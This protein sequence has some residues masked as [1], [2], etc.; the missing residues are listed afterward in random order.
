[1]ADIKTFPAPWTLHGYGYIILFKA[2]SE[3]LKQHGF[4]DAGNLD[5]YVP[6]VGTAMLVN[7]ESSTAGGYGELLFIPGKFQ[8]PKGK[9]YSISKIF[10]STME[11]VINGQ[12][13]WGIPKE[14]AQFEFTQEEQGIEHIR[15]K[16]DGKLI[17]DCRIQ[18]R[19][20]GMPVTT[21][22]LPK[23]LRTVAQY[24]K[25]KLFYTSPNA[26]S[27]LKLSKLLSAEFNTEHFPDLNQVKILGVVKADNMTME[28]PVPE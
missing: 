6:S 17:A 20:W 21:A 28:F 1:M 19:S 2:E 3:W 26:R 15:I 22:L 7:Y 13:N 23:S 16:K 18:T 5:S 4:I 24:W 8:M 9:R 12:N 10:V 27:T 11:S 14:L 25:D